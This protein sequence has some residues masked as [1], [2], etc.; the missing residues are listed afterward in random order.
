[1]A[2]T[3]TCGWRAARSRWTAA[4]EDRPLIEILHDRGPMSQAH[5]REQPPRASFREPSCPGPAY[6]HP[7]T[8][9]R[10]AAGSVAKS[11]VFPPEGIALPGVTRHGG[12]ES[13]ESR[14]RVH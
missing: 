12:G 13:G 11:Q 1:M 14:V 2:L 4:S 5:L 3:K 7:P 10:V 6:E 8:Q 9:W